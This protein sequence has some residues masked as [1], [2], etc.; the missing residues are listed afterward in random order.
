MP[1]R[2]ERVRV[3]VRRHTQSED[4]D[5][6]TADSTYT[7]NDWVTLDYLVPISGRRTFMLSRS[8]YEADWMAKIAHMRPGAIQ[9]GDRIVTFVDGTPELFLQVDN[10]LREGQEFFII[11][12]EE[13]PVQS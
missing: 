8:D 12:D 3:S 1:T 13:G 2:R 5:W 9:E 7:H 4:A 11:L 6:L 10:V